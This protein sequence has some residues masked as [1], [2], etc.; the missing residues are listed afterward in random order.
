MTR[1]STPSLALHS[2]TVWS[3]EAESTARPSQQKRTHET[4]EQCPAPP[5]PPS[6]RAPPRARSN[7]ISSLGSRVAPTTSRGL[8]TSGEKARSVTLPVGCEQ[9]DEG[10]KRWCSD[11]Q[12]CA[13]YGCGCRPARP[14]AP[15]PP[16]PQR[17]SSRPRAECL[18]RRS[19]AAPPP[20]PAAGPAR[21]RGGTRGCGGAPRA[22]MTL[23]TMSCCCA[24]S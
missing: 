1:C 18:S 19:S 22:P 8:V 6:T 4:V 20:P 23:R 24:P 5:P 2:R 14:T 3:Y 7:I 11:R 17:H 15:P 12:S 21:R 16:T 9:T 10:A 13:A